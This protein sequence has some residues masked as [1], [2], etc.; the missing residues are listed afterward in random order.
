ME[1]EGQAGV[2]GGEEEGVRG[3]AA[4]GPV[5]PSLLHPLTQ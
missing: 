1:R 5:A 3:V 2:R 4:V